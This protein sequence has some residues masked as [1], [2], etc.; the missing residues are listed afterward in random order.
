[1]EQTSAG[2]GRGCTGNTARQPIRDGHSNVISHE[3]SNFLS[4]ESRIFRNISVD[5]RSIW[6]TLAEGG[7]GGSRMKF[8]KWGMGERIGFIWHRIC[9][10]GGLLRTRMFF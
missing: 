6:N 1:M 10:R 3:A 5:L 9:A 4:K 2:C 8:L 7:G